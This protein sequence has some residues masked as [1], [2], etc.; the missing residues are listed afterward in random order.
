MSNQQVGDN[1][2]IIPGDEAYLSF[3]GWAK[4]MVNPPKMHERR[5]F[6]VDTECTEASTKSSEKGERSVRKLSILRV[7]EVAGV[8]V[9]PADKDEN[10][11]ELL[12]EDELRTAADDA[13]ESSRIREENAEAKVTNYERA[14]GDDEEDGPP[15]NVVGFSAKGK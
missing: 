14:G 6:I 8:V 1:D 15:D 12:S 13:E 5:R 4:P 10:Q 11:G 9:P 3:G 7:A 2:I